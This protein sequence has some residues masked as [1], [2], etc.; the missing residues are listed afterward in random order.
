MSAD[1]SSPKRQCVVHQSQVFHYD[2]TFFGRDG[3]LPAPADFVKLIQPLFKKWCFQ[4]EACPTTGRHHYQGRG[5]LFK[6]R[7]HPELCGILNQ[8]ELRGMDVSESSN[9]SLNLEVFYA[10]KYDTRLEGPW[11]DDLW[12]VPAY[13]P[14]QFRG[15][16]DRLFPWQ[17]Q[18][19]NSK[20]TFND[21]QINLIYDTGG[22]QG[23]S[24]C[25]RLAQLHHN[26]LRL[27][28]VG[29]HKQLL[30]AACDILM[31]KK[32][33]EPGL[34]FVDLP[35]TLTIDPKR[36]AP[37]LIAVEEIKAGVVCDM[38]N[39][40]KE[41][42]FDSPAVWVFAN[43]LPNLNWMSADRWVFWTIDPLTRSLVSHTRDQMI[44]MI[45]SPEV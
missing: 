3:V 10:L 26:S 41:W 2:F 30:E 6:K 9:N 12:V 39:H 24:T 33:R 40:F 37:F 38:R 14:R 36:F 25:A 19:L 42:W 35:R 15:L 43:H 13:I 45:Q 4:L 32:N 23:K 18:V 16:E 1:E 34:A 8:C 22:C 29:D 17:Q 27:P 5:S 11:R 7:R 28:P 31:A 20:D 21:R 44:Q